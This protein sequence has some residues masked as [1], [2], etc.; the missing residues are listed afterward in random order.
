MRPTPRRVD[1][2]RDHRGYISDPAIGSRLARAYHALRKQVLEIQDRL[3]I[4]SDE[5]VDLARVDKIDGGAKPVRL[6]GAKN[7]AGGLRECSLGL[8]LRV[9]DLVLMT[10]V[11]LLLFWIVQ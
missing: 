4:E 3:D 1:R 6:P 7:D 10:D 9:V 8:Q 2:P 5:F 11:P